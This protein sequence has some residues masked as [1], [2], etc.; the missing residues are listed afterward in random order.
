MYVACHFVTL[1]IHTIVCI[2]LLHIFDAPNMF[3]QQTLLLQ[4]DK[5]WYILTLLWDNQPILGYI[6]IQGDRG[7]VRCQKMVFGLVQSSH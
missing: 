1:A 2:I 3:L 5:S 7:E 6:T 4:K